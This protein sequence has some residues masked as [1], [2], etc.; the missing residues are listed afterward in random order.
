MVARLLTSVVPPT[1]FLLVSW[2]VVW[3]GDPLWG[4]T[5]ESG[6]TVAVRSC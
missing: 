3:S 6:A 5:A 1:P 4:L 2:D